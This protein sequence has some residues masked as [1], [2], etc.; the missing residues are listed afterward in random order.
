MNVDGVSADDRTSSEGATGPN[1]LEK[2]RVRLAADNYNNKGNSYQTLTDDN[3]N[4]RS[5]GSCTAQP[6]VFF[7]R[8]IKPGNCYR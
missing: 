1:P 2:L 7:G 8:I 4:D 6:S 5:D 3:D